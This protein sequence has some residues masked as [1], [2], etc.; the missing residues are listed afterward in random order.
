[1]EYKN[2]EKENYSEEMKK[3]QRVQDRIRQAKR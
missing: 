3:W 2:W 1:M